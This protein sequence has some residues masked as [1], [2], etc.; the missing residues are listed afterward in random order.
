[1][2]NT[3][4]SLLM[5]L[6]TELRCYIYDYFPE[7][8]FKHVFPTP[9]IGTWAELRMPTALLQV[10]KTILDEAQQ[11]LRTRNMQKSPKVTIGPKPGDDNGT[12][13]ISLVLASW[14]NEIILPLLL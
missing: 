1:M 3:D 10:N 6:P 5:A 9:G 7:R 12:K 8:V 4:K 11:H 13:L 2:Q 14:Y